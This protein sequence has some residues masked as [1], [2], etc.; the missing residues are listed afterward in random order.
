MFLEIISWKMNA[1]KA[2]QVSLNKLE[3]CSHQTEVLEAH[4]LIKFIYVEMFQK[5]LIVMRE[6]ERW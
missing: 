4:S 6:R 2:N 5:T 1:W 3:M